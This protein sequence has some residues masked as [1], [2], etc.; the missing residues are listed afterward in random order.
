MADASEVGALLP[1]LAP[2]ARPDDQTDGDPDES[3]VSDEDA[4]DEKVA[5]GRDAD[6]EAEDDWTADWQA[7]ESAGDE[8]LWSEP[9]PAIVIDRFGGELSVRVEEFG[10]ASE[11]RARALSEIGEF[12]VQRFAEGLRSGDAGIL[13]AGINDARCSQRDLS[14]WL[15]QRRTPLDRHDVSRAMKSLVVSVSG[16]GDVRLSWFLRGDA[17]RTEDKA[18]AEIA[19]LRA[20]IRHTLASKPSMPTR[21][22]TAVLRRELGRAL[23]EE[24]VRR[25]RNA[26]GLGAQRA[27][28]KRQS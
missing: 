23:S 17:R 5:Y 11:A 25:H 24:T 27:Q 16:V 1:G 22:L 7:G 12:L 8:A 26:V 2:D 3:S 10:R 20:R 6:D 15:L 9:E 4:Y 18:P 28:R 14:R 19:Q 13:E 21:L